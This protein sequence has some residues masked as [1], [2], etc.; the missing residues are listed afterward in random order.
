M[1]KNDSKS[2]NRAPRSA[3][4]RAKQVARKPW[5]PPSMLETPPKHLKDILTGG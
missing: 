5:R 2:N 3:E 4:T 1:D